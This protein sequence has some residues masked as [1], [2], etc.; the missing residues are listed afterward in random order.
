LS[1]SHRRLALLLAAWIV[2]VF[3]LS[4]CA[5]TARGTRNSVYQEKNVAA[6]VINQPTQSEALVVIRYPAIISTEAER[7]FYQ[8]FSS[9][10]IG[11][12]VPIEVKI[13]RD[14][15]RVAQA[16]IAKTN[17]YVMSLYHE[18]RK[19][20]PANSVLLS[21]HMIDWN[22]ED[23]LHSRPMLAS[24]QVPS[25]ITIDFSVYSYP[26]VRKIMDSPPLTFG[27]IVTPLMVVHS[28]RWLRPATNGLLLASEPLTQSS[29]QLSAQQADRQFQSML[30]YPSE[31]YQRPLDFINFLRYGESGN[32]SVP[33]KNI[34]DSTIEV[35]AVEKY[36]VEK[37][38]MN[39][40]LVARLSDANVADPFRDAFVNGATSRIL[41]L[42]NTIDRDR[43]LFF[44]R[45]ETLQRF[46]PELSTVYLSRSGQEDVRARLLLAEALIESEK[47]FLSSQS[48]SVFQGTYEGE[49]GQKMRR[50]I[51]AEYGMLEERR[52]LAR[53]QNVTTAV[54]VAM[55]AGS[56]YGTS[57]SGS[58]VASALQSITGVLVLGSVWAIS[59]TVKT[60]QK[61]SR[62]TE[63]FIALMAPELDRQIAVQMEW[64]E[65]KEQ[66]TARGF[67]E[68]RDKTQALYQSRV[69]SLSIR[70][71]Q[72]CVFR[73]PQV[74]QAGRWY[75]DCIDGLANGR[76]YGLVRD[77][78]GYSVE[79]LGSTERGLASG[80]GGMILAQA[81]QA[82]PIYYE[83]RFSNGMPDGV[84]QVEEAGKRPR[85][86]TFRMG[87]D[88]GKASA[89][90]W[91]PL[92][93]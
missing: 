16:V 88:T 14:T 2:A 82:S 52:R 7:P 29:W 57:V 36:P 13:R 15:E 3:V 74:D 63:K 77:A 5:G 58:A 59:S 42:L 54:A 38:Q 43:A 44:A 41:T 32:S 89:K 85:L 11:G 71:D 64:M 30:A 48:A 67:A 22:R 45:Q 80:I 92:A 84:V 76:G 86:R 25:V 12:A 56:V 34:G 39:S 21:P 72:N 18:L 10:A 46:D 24:E 60:S 33:Q 73:H 17:Y 90:E 70:G 83:G 75:G 9:N 79:Y 68:F 23:E 55:L 8:A 4:A 62:I 87:N 27:D 91:S 65:S 47:V 61:S 35:Q 51:E 93:F 40:E 53:I 50:M 81:D 37:I 20:L 31:R 49:Y 1:A 28:N 69:R 78:G 6:D 66:I 26:D 19:E